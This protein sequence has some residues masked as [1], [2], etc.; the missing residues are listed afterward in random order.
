MEERTVFVKAGLGMRK[1]ERDFGY[2]V[3]LLRNSS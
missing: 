2:P 1:V 3:W